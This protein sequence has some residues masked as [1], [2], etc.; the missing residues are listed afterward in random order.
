M[1]GNCKGDEHNVLRKT[2]K[3]IFRI[4][5]SPGMRGSPGGISYENLE[6]ELVKSLTRKEERS[7]SQSKE[8]E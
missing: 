6:L 2:S 8:E 7:E 1:V 3:G 4:K 5:R